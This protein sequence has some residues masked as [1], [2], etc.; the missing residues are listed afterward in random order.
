MKLT[1][2]TPPDP[3]QTDDRDEFEVPPA[4]LPYTLVTDAAGMQ[5]V[6]HV[7]I[8]C[9]RVG[10]D[11]ETTGLSPHKDKVRLLSLAIPEIEGPASVYLVDCF[12]VNPTPLWG[13][14][15]D[16]V[17]LT[18][19]GL[20]DLQF[21]ARLGFQPDPDKA[22]DTMLL[23][24]LLDG[25]RR[26]KK[27]HSLEECVKRHLGRELPKDMQKS[28]WSGDLSP[29]QLGY[30]ARDAAVLLD[31]QVALE[32]KVGEAKLDR[33]A[34][35]E[36]RCL[37]A[38]AWMALHG[39]GFDREAW[40]ALATEA[41]AEADRLAE[42]L[43]RQAPKPDQPEMFGSGWN[44]DSPQQV[45]GV[46][47]RLGIELEKTDDDALAAVDHPLAGLIRR[48]R[49]A[50][51]R[52]S[53]Y[54]TAWLKHVAE[55]GRVYA[56]WQQLGADSGRMACRDPNLQNLPKDDRYRRCF[57]APP[58]RVLV[59]ADYSQIELRIACK[60]ANEKR[61][62]DAYRKG[63]DLH[64]LTAR[65]VTGKNDVTK[66]DRKLAKAINFGLLYGMG[67]KGFRVYARTQYGVELSLD[68]AE[69]YRAAFFSTYPGLKRWHRSIA[70]GEVET[71]T[72]TG[73]RRSSVRA[74]TEK[75]NTPVQGTGADGLKQ[76]LALLWER[77]DVVEGAVPVLAVHDEIVVEC[78][79]DH[80]EA[81]AV[82]LKQAMLDG[83]APLIAPV[84]VEVEVSVG[85]TWGGN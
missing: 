36:A 49:S 32:A 4:E 19:N 69:C 70:D 83:M 85:R 21:L 81:V 39:V 43:D 45:Q 46:F 59:R 52:S 67:A 23:S 68:E 80:A 40:S 11:A 26:P 37:A 3:P 14:L 16:N 71:R 29:E 41:Q 18:H 55:D 1:P 5:K 30:A 78:D 74:F 75:L 20:F 77:R 10:L 62:L 8:D 73:R 58:G 79:A 64:T 47:A 84:P 66:E 15:A 51:K 12:A 61:M 72:L 34:G 24:R 6:A 17:L 65:Q 35:V 63:E 2:L 57:I 42:E 7:L 53:T 31:L 28:N 44:W 48:Y 22:R 56:G 60:I 38:V 27:F 50:A 82:W 76:A 54:G 33:V 9:P 25:T 13:G